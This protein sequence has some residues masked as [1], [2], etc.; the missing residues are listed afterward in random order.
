MRWKLVR[1]FAKTEDKFEKDGLD[2]IDA[3]TSSLTIGN[4]WRE[5]FKR[6][7]IFGPARPV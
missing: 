2:T 3:K 6:H 1:R 4:M 5:P 7:R